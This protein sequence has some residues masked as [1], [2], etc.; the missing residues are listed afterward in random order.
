MTEKACSTCGP[1]TVTSNAYF[2]TVPTGT[3]KV[4]APTGTTVGSVP[5]GPVQFT[6]AAASNKG[7][8]FAGVAAALVAMVL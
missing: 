7:L 3:A 8:G 4:T 1:A 2:T 6:G 5:T